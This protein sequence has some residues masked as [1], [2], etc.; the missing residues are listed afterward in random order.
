[1]QQVVK[2][3]LVQIQLNGLLNNRVEHK[4]KTI[5]IIILHKNQVKLTCNC[6]RLLKRKPQYELNSWIEAG[7]WMILLEIIW[8]FFLLF[9]VCDFYNKF[10]LH[11]KV[12]WIF[13]IFYPSWLKISHTRF[14]WPFLFSVTAV[15]WLIILPTF[16]KCSTYYYEPW[17]P[18][19]S[20]FLKNSNLQ[21]S[22][23]I[24]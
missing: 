12:D 5:K 16:T 15:H 2:W 20:L 21:N 24:H 18:P 8:Y 23:D 22:I 14:A 10:F 3:N 7:S 11:I 17:N 13:P 19:F 1:M 6:K 9:L 4:I